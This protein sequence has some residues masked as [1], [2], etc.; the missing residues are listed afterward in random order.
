MYIFIRSH[1]V[2]PWK[3][4]KLWNIHVIIGRNADFRQYAQ[5]PNKNEWMQSRSLHREYDYWQLSI[6]ETDSFVFCYQNGL[7]LKW[8]KF[9]SCHNDLT[10]FQDPHNV[11]QMMHHTVPQGTIVPWG[12]ALCSAILR[13]L[14]VKSCRIIWCII[15]REHIIETLVIFLV[16]ST[17]TSKDF[18]VCN[19]YTVRAFEHFIVHPKKVFYTF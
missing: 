2:Y 4:I 1:W 3:W 5:W 11:M 8:V 6:F 14:E 9:I 10:S 17:C 16:L 18:K 15:Q 7:D 12:T 13:S 19:S